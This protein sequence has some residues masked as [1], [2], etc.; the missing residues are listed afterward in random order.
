MPIAVIPHIYKMDI[1][2]CLRKKQNTSQYSAS[3]PAKGA[4]AQKGCDQPSE[5]LVCL[6]QSI[7]LFPST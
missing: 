7:E 2:Q 5:L 4:E 1:L 6:K 3:V